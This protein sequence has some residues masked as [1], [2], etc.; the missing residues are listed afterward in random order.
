MRKKYHI[1]KVVYFK[2]VPKYIQKYNVNNNNLLFVLSLINVLVTALITLNTKYLRQ[3]CN[4]C[5]NTKPCLVHAQE[6]LL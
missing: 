2:I 6:L 5:L 3:S 1:L 4:T